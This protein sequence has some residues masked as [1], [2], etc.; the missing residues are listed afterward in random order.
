MSSGEPAHADHEPYCLTMVLCD[1]VHRDPITG[2]FTILGTFHGIKL[3]SFPTEVRV[4]VYFA[5]TDMLGTHQ[6]RLQVVNASAHLDDDDEETLFTSTSE[7]ACDDPLKIHDA[8]VV[9][10]TKFQ[11]PGIYYVELYAGHSPVMSRRLV[12]IGPPPPPGESHE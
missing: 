1:N 9:F 2:K 5:L 6:V 10:K 12:I 4:V 8:V 3:R 11:K 7:I